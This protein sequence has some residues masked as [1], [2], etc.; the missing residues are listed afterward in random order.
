M[1]VLYATYTVTN[2]QTAT[3]TFSSSSSATSNSLSPYFWNPASMSLSFRITRRRSNTNGLCKTQQ[4]DLALLE[5]ISK[6]RILSFRKGDTSRRTSSLARCRLLRAYTVKH[7][8][9]PRRIRD[10]VSI[11]AYYDDACFPVTSS[12]SPISPITAVTF[13]WKHFALGA[14]SERNHM[15]KAPNSTSSPPSSPTRIT[16]ASMSRR[17]LASNRPALRS[18]LSFTA[19]CEPVLYTA[20]SPAVPSSF[21]DSSHCSTPVTPDQQVLP[22]PFYPP[23]PLR[24]RAQPENPKKFSSLWTCSP[25]SSPASVSRS[26]RRRICGDTPIESLTECISLLSTQEHFNML[27]RRLSYSRTTGIAT[28]SPFRPLRAL[29]FHNTQNLQSPVLIRSSNTLESPRCFPFVGAAA[30]RCH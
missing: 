10:L 6:Y 18:R 24:T 13:P 11:V 30:S 5:G 23:S 14:S 26:V 8:L 9:Q 28:L 15:K 4:A 12:E 7:N 29:P 1:H 17:R 20:A 3:L 25:A 21:I 19:V 22:M 2:T 16:A 27:P